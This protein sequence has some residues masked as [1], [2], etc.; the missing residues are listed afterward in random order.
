LACQPLLQAQNPQK[1]E[2]KQKTE[3][4]QTPAQ[5]ATPAPE[6]KQDEYVEYPSPFGPIRVLK[7]LGQPAPTATVPA[8]AQVPSPAPAAQQPPTT[9][10]AAAASPEATPTAAQEAAGGSPSNIR[11]QLDHA[12]LNQIINIIGNELK[13]NYVVD[14]RVKGVATI[15]TTGDLRREDLL[16]LLDTILKLNGAAIVKTGNFF[17]I[18]PKADIKQL[19]VPIR[20]DG[21]PGTLK[22]DGGRVMQVLPMRFVSAKDM[23]KVLEPFLSEGGNIVVHEGSNILIITE[24]NA[25]LKRLLELVNIFDADIFQ[26]KRVQ[27]YPVKFNRAKDVVSDLESIFGAYAFSRKESAIRF[28]AIDRMNAVMAVSL[29]PGSL[30]EVGKWVQK[31]DQPGENVGNKNYVYKAQNGNAKNIAAVLVSIYSGKGDA[32]SSLSA[33]P[34]GTPGSAL[35]QATPVGTTTGAGEGPPQ[36]GRRTELLHENIKIVADEIT[37]SVIVQSS[38]QDWEAIRET[39]KALDIVPRQVLIDAK[40]YEVNLTGALSMGVSAFLQQRSTASKATTASFTATGTDII[41]KGLNV[42]TGTLIGNTRE[43]LV[44]LNAQE[45]RTRTR[46]LSSPSVIASDNLDARI[47]VGSEVPILTSQGVVPGGTGSQG[48]FSNTVQQRSTGVILTVTP[49]INA[50]GWVTLKIAQ[51]VS[52]PVAPEA[53]SAIQ[54]PSISIRSVNTQVTVMDGETI[55]IGGIIAENRLLS[56]NRVPLLGDIP[57]VGLLFGNT[58]YSNVRTEL[59]ALITPHVIEN[60]D[61]AADVTEELKSQLKSLKKDLQ[62]IAP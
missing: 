10:P 5:K 7:S 16:P 53:G 37:N 29:N 36:A 42:A 43:L 28:L 46:V 58:N 17:Q 3:T 24:T 62:M 57:G 18:V 30:E 21:Q 45:S 56:K 60:V 38:P 27:V 12:D 33:G 9:P 39:I 14:P 55:A 19:P 41:S 34:E 6:K 47:Q 61:Q 8:G 44:F 23:S 49:R 22:S 4:P 11:L 2:E 52:S 48:L 51:E 20:T 25:N 1:P 59:I 15:N 13:I 54:S 32:I 31:L 26:N 35:S 40:I 50:G